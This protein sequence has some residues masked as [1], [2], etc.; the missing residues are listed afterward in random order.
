MDDSVTRTSDGHYQLSMSWKKGV[1]ISSDSYKSVLTH[2]NS[3]KKRLPKDDTYHSKYTTE[4]NQN[5]DG[6]DGKLKTVDPVWYL[7]HHPVLNPINWVRYKIVF[8]CA[9]KYQ[10]VSLND[11][12]LS[13]PDLTNSLVGVLIRFHHSTNMLLLLLV[14]LKA[15]SARCGSCPKIT[16][17]WDSCGDLK[18]TCPRSL[19]CKLVHLFGVTS[20]PDCTTFT[21]H[22]TAEDHKH[23]FDEQASTAVFCNFYVDDC[24]KSVSTEKEVVCLVSQ[25]TKLLKSIRF[26][27]IRLTKWMSDDLRVL[28]SIP[29]QSRLHKLVSV[30][31]DPSPPME[32][33]LGIPWNVQG[34]RLQFSVMKRDKPITL[35]GILCHQLSLWPNGVHS[36][37]DPAS[38]MASTNLLSA[39]RSVIKRSGGGK[40]G[41]ET[42]ASCRNWLFLGVCFYS[43]KLQSVSWNFIISQDVLKCG[44]APMTYL[45]FYSPDAQTHM[46]LVI[47]NFRLDPLKTVTFGIWNCPQQFGPSH[48]FLLQ[49]HS[50]VHPKSKNQVQDLCGKP[51][52]LHSWQHWGSAVALCGH[53]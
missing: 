20:S 19:Q 51:H 40:I 10:G 29:E 11:Q 35:R 45:W 46:S 26:K 28:Q 12:L 3:L 34:D 27:S 41:S 18:A 37:C 6:P 52:F 25:L 53:W 1:L 8:D 49:N 23:W 44:Y 5:L 15:C 22:K 50:G 14:T 24:L 48:H 4:M 36:L 17:S 7:P 13:E 30:N 32:K 47:K 31:M 16:T 42:W 2:L 38:Q 33:T 39:E 21:L 9:A 43:G